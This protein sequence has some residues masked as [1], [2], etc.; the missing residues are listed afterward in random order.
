MYT[1]TLAPLPRFRELL[2]AA[3]HSTFP[4]DK[5]AKP[6][7][8]EGDSCVWLSRSAWSMLAIA[9]WCAIMKNKKDIVVWVPDFF[10]NTSL[11]PLRERGVRLFFYKITNGLAP[12]L[13]WCRSQSDEIYPDLF[14]LVHYFG[15]PVPANQVA[16]FCKDAGAWLI[17]DAAHVLRPIPGVGNNG[18]FVLYSPHKHIAIPD[19]AILVIRKNGPAQFGLNSIALTKLKN[20]INSIS[21]RSNRAWQPQAW[22]VKR[23]L[24]K[25]GIRK[26]NPKFPLWP[27][28]IQEKILFPPPK[29]SS[30]AKSLLSV[31]ISTLDDVA[32][33]RKEHFQDWKEK[34]LISNIN[35]WSLKHYSI[36]T[37]PYLVCIIGKDLKTVENFYLS[38]QMANLPVLTWPDLPPEVI[39][40]SEL[41]KNALNL[42]KKRFYLSVH[43]TLKSSQIKEV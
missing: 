10:C 24:Q 9:D 28:A 18:D 31:Q 33:L 13:D 6:W 15:E 27:E 41:H 39:A 21:S 26:K 20:V 19:G 1:M 25:L 12:D 17:E 32:N 3:T 40:E 11:A 14:I 43:Q 35:S 4:D 37:T 5:L 7:L 16:K 34:L 30:L 36:N 8:R 2:L 22:L 42:R 29:M 23:V 38:L